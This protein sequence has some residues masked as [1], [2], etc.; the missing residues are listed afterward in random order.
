[1]LKGES[2]FVLSHMAE[3]VTRGMGVHLKEKRSGLGVSL[4]DEP[5]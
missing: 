2:D 1:M 3:A 5:A 4:E